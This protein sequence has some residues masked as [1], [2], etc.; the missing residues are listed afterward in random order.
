MC[1]L[2]CCGLPSTGRI[3]SGPSGCVQVGIYQS[4]QRRFRNF[5]SGR[6]GTE[7]TSQFLLPGLC[8]RPRRGRKKRH[9]SVSRRF[10]IER[11]S[12]SPRPFP[13]VDSVS[14]ISR[15]FYF[16]SR[17]TRSTTSLFLIPQPLPLFLC[18]SSFAPWL[19]SVTRITSFEVSRS[20]LP[21]LL[22]MFSCVQLR[23]TSEISVPSLCTFCYS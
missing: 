1:G 12:A 10:P 2:W 9:S 21:N 8:S 11:R 5:D 23:F 13:A 19:Q 17:I 3:V 16:F 22:K 18:F 15:C 14:R 4:L 6:V 7:T 20:T